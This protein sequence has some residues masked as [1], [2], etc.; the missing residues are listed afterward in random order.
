VRAR[1]AVNPLALAKSVL[2]RYARNGDGLR[3]EFSGPQDYTFMTVKAVYGNVLRQLI[4]N[5]CEYAP[6]GSGVEVR[7]IAPNAQN[8]VELSIANEAGELRETELAQLFNAFWRGNAPRT[9]RHHLG[10]GLSI[11]QSAAVLLG[12]QLSA[13]WHD[14]TIVFHFSVPLGE[15]QSAKPAFGE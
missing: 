2:T 11:A 5:A 15:D 1:E 6:A 14:G 7:L 13:Q 10:L 8:C 3:W 12:G 9:Q 4:S